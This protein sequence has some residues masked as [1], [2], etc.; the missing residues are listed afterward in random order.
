MRQTIAGE[1]TE[2]AP[3]QIQA[4]ELLL[5][6]PRLDDVCQKLSISRQCLWNWLH[7]DSDFRLHLAER[8]AEELSA[9]TRRLI[10]LCAMA[11]DTLEKAM[12]G[13]KVSSQ[14]LQASS[15][16]LKRTPEL[17]QTVALSVRLAELERRFLGQSQE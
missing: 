12:N 3:G 16:T 17:I 9:A 15:I 1:V 14:A 4:I 8:E 10:T 7:R 11:A 2:L 13:E 5:T 6:T